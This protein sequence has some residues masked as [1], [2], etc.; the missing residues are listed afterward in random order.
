MSTGTSVITVIIC[1]LCLFL[2]IET[3]THALQVAI[4]ADACDRFNVYRQTHNNLLL[5]QGWAI[6]FTQRA[7][8]RKILK[9]QAALVGGAKKRSSR[10]QVS[11]FYH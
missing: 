2:W 3:I 10:P 11:C 4:F 6:M 9:P 5:H 1:S 7:A 8:N